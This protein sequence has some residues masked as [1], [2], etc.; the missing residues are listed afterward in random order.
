MRV[1]ITK[2]SVAMRAAEFDRRA[3]PDWVHI[4]T[5]SGRGHNCALPVGARCPL[6]INPATYQPAARGFMVQ[7]AVCLATWRVEAIGKRGSEGPTIG[8]VQFFSTESYGVAPQGTPL[9]N[10]DTAWERP[11]ASSINWHASR[12][13][14]PNGE[15]WW[16]ID[17]VELRASG[18]DGCPA[19]TIVD[20]ESRFCLLLFDHDG[21][22][23]TLDNAGRP[24]GLR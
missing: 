5:T 18:D 23:E 8:W 11:I 4:D 24:I 17:F 10:G 9:F 20:H 1:P 22:H 2:L 6:P 16:Q 15:Q 7:C 3:H 21:D 19:T 12:P 14:L 13:R